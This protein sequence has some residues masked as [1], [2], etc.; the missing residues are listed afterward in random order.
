[1]PFT[2][3]RFTPEVTGD[4]ELEH[5]HRYIMAQR[6]ASDKTV[7]DI[8][9]GEGYGSCLLANV[10]KHVIGVDISED[11]VNHASRKYCKGNL[12]F[13]VGN[14]AKIPLRD[15]SVE[16]VVSYETIEHHD[17]HEAMMAEIRR[18]LKP[19]GV[20]I[21][22]S[23]DKHEFSDV[24][25]YRNPFHVKELYRQDFEKLMATHFKHVALFGQR[26]VYGSG[27]FL[28]NIPG[29]FVSYN[30]ADAFSSSHHSCPGVWR[31]LYLIAI[32]SDENLPATT[33]SFL[34][35]PILESNIVRSRDAQITNLY[36]V[37]SEREQH[38][39]N[40]SQI[41]AARESEV[42]DLKQHA[43]NLSQIVAARESEVADL[44]QHAANLSQIVAACE[45]EV[46]N[47]QKSLAEREEQIRN[48]QRIAE[49][50]EFLEGQLKDAKIK[51]DEFLS[52]TS[53]RIT[54]PLRIL[55]G[56]LRKNR[57]PDRFVFSDQL[58]LS[59][60]VPLNTESGEQQTNSGLVDSNF[61]AEFYCKAYP[62]THGL[63]P[64]FHYSNFGKNEGR[65]PCAPVPVGIDELKNLDRSKETVLIVSH[66]AS[67]TGAPILA[68]NIAQHLKEKYNVIAF[69]LRGG[70]LLADFQEH[71]D[72]VVEPFPQ[73]HNPFAV[74]IVLEQ[75]I[76]QAGLKFAI[77]NSIV[78]RSV[79][80]ALSNN[81]VPS[82]CLIHEFASYTYPKSAIR[83]VVLWASQVVFSARIVYEN[84]AIQ[85]DVLDGNNPVILPQGKCIVPRARDTGIADRNEKKRIRKL[86][87]PDH[88]PD[89]TVVILGAGYVQL[90]KGVDL[91]LSCAAR[92]VAL[93][94]QNAFRFVWVGHGFDTDLDLAYSTYLQDQ[95]NR[96][97]LE[98]YVCFTGEMSD[99]DLAYELSDVLFLSSRLDPLPNVAID[100]MY[101]QLP[102]ICFDNTTGIADLL[103]ENG[104]GESCV[105]PY[106]DVEQAA[107]RIF[108]LIEDTDRRIMLGKEINEVGKKL[109]DMRLYV[110]SLERQAMNCLAT[111]E[112]EK[113]DC[114]VIEENEILNFDFFLPPA[115]SALSYKKAVRAF[116]RTWRSGID[117]RKPFPGF[118]PGIYEDL[119]GISQAGNN[120]LVAFI[121]AGKPEG[122]WL[123]D[124][125]QPSI[126]VQ[127]S[128]KQTL[129][130]ALHI[131]VFFVDLFLDILQR[132]E[133]QNLHLDLLI[134]VPSLEVAQEVG[135][136]VS[137]Y[138]N[139]TVDIRT[140]PNRGRD[141]GPFLTEFSETILKNYDVI[142][143]VHS[144]KSV[145]VQD[146]SMGQ[147]WFI[148][149]L[150][151]L[152][153]KKYS[154]ASTILERMADNEKLGLVFPDDPYIIGWSGNKQIAENLAHQFGIKE[155]P[156]RHF[157]FPVGTMFWARTAALKP[158]LTNDFRWEDYPEEPLPY[159]GT[160]LH[161]LERLLPF[162]AKK[163]G[164][165]MS[166]THVPGITR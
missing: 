111:Q 33:S 27:L 15:N 72:I 63:D 78:S 155:L 116:V 93:C 54:E 18:V 25:N 105:M 13:K 138:A 165:H 69:L 95:I 12:E 159:D 36:Q 7:L 5:L 58:A 31:P 103:K 137:G 42:A 100:A 56:C 126:P 109:F 20:V 9:C 97:G 23:P 74:S 39:T 158:L 8:A 157:N 122:P 132:L 107:L 44:K 17:Q 59:E 130:A 88:L 3:E 156:D 47:L 87:R 129:R 55:R 106:L 141:I 49:R 119:H 48:L 108:S 80:P 86:F 77:V 66:E 163:M 113:G 84:N 128:G 99:I 121:Q 73:S 51:I 144:K 19:D 145:D 94:P 124:L 83:D 101:Q 139:G 6:F 64:Y 125:I 112:I 140:V 90:R 123:C 4:I 50:A 89:N 92:V 76:S 60:V 65:L 85:C 10:A 57:Q 29:D 35:Q 34:D 127:M 150:E 81:F 46:A 82:L 14:C 79:L 75:L 53:W 30:A 161:S 52:S 160:I 16:L 149:L 38:T 104:L 135:A 152:I 62:D 71:C 118:H 98:N 21:I 110:D 61:D 28:E 45:S 91:F 147:A 136:L 2:G 151:N 142:G 117:M 114:A 154:M 11:A 134:S 43:I 41:V 143:H 146:L 120:P 131:H 166:M 96:A 164:Y 37:L 24:P 162:V 26:V 70:D 148:F 22:S 102:V 133:G 68:L 40:L 67:R 115:W 1:M 153:G 32:A